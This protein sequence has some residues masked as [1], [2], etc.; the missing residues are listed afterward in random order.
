MFLSFG[1]V[2]QTVSYHGYVDYSLSTPAEDMWFDKSEPGRGL[3]LEIQDE[4]LLITLFGYRQDG[5]S[6]WWQGVG[7]Q[8]GDSNVYKDGLP[9]LSDGL[10]VGCA[11]SFPVEDA[12]NSIGDF[13]L[14]FSGGNDA[15]FEWAGKD[16]ELTKYYYGYA[17]TLDRAKGVWELRAETHNFRNQVK[18]FCCLIELKPVLIKSTFLLV[19]K[20][21]PW[22]LLLQQPICLKP[23]MVRRL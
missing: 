18:E 11:Y 17:D 14:T 19:M 10:C 3:S 5:A 21:V 4:R 22:V 12:A 20:Q 13:T 7:V 15:L 23:V 16:I 8:E 6:Q 1:A 2:G 9:A